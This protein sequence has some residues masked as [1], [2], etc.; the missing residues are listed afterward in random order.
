M[1]HYVM[2]KFRERMKE[3]LDWADKGEEVVIHRDGKVYIV[4]VPF[5]PEDYKKE[6]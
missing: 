4:K 2:S 5:R 1:K 6:E 3:A